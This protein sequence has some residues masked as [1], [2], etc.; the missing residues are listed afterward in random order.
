MDKN[1]KVVVHIGGQRFPLLTD[2]REDY[3]LQ[4]ANT[5]DGKMQE[6]SLANPKLNRD[7][8]AMLAA[9]DFCDMLE[10]EKF[11]AVKREQEIKKLSAEL[12]QEKEKASSAQK[13]LLELQKKL[14]LVTQENEKLRSDAK[15][16]LVEQQKRELSPGKT[17]ITGGRIQKGTAPSESVHNEA[18]TAKNSK[19]EKN[20][21]SSAGKKTS[22]KADS[23]DDDCDP[24]QYNFFKHSKAAVL[25]ALQQL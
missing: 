6:I 17:M 3:I 13:E 2:E 14:D 18:Q 20:T 25:E 9:L 10:K 1:K 7:G 8:G 24:R 23:A 11:S 4:L 5:V 12:K 19:R 21:Q 22:A 15:H 16:L